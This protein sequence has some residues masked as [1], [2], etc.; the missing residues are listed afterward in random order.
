[1]NVVKESKNT[2]IHTHRTKIKSEKT[3]A[4]SG[5][6]TLSND[7]QHSCVEIACDATFVRADLQSPIF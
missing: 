4:N 6:V 1:M 5:I 7:N 3:N 2:H